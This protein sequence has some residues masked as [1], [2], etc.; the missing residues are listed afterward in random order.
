MVAS[1]VLETEIAADGGTDLWDAG[2]L[3]SLANGGTIN[4]HH[5]VGQKLGRFMRP[6][7]G[8]GFDVLRATKHAWDPDGIMNP[9]KLGFGPPS[10][11]RWP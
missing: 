9:G 6:Q 4:E 2:V 10:T 11:G 1:A 3:T 5:G 8:N 7:Y